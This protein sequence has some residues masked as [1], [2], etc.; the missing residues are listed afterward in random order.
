MP[1]SDGGDDFVRVGFPEEGSWLAVVLGEEAVDGGLKVDDRA[2]HAAFQAALR[3]D[4]VGGEKNDLG[5]PSVFLGGVAVLGDG[6][7]DDA[8]T[9]I[10]PRACQTLARVPSGGNPKNELNRQILSASLRIG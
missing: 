4:A 5:A 6:L 8:A 2:E 10:F 3:A 1:S 9:V 7:W